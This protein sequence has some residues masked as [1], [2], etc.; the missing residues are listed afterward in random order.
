MDTDWAAYLLLLAVAY[1]VPGPDFVLVLNWATRRRRDGLLAGL[2]AQTGLCVHVLACVGGVSVVVQR[3]PWTL[4]VLQVLGAG[5]LMWLGV[6]TARSTATQGH[7]GSNPRGAFMQGLGT[8]LLNP[9]A[10]V[11]VT[12]V[13]PQFARGTWP[14]P[15][16]LAVLGAV[17]VGIGLVVWAVLVAVGAHLARWLVRPQVQRRWQRANGVLLIVIGM[18]LALTHVG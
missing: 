5:Y 15:V 17:D 10:I 4:T 13:L 8:N 12:S 16:Q 7:G 2:G 3:W 1:V 18:L 6:Q 14:L 11:F 9:K